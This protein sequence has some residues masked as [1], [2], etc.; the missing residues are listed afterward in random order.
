MAYR[1]TT[2]QDVEFLHDTSAPRYAYESDEEDQLNPLSSGC[3][4]KTARVSISIK[5][6]AHSQGTAK[7][8]VIA[9][10][11]AGN[12]WARGAQLGEQRAAVLV[13][14]IIVALIFLP[15]WSDAVVIISETSATL[16]AW[17]MRPYAEAIVHFY[18]PSRLLLLDTYPFPTCIKPQPLDI[19]HAPVC[20]LRTQGKAAPASFL[21]PY[22]PPNLIQMTCAAFTSIAALPTSQM[23]AILLLLP[24][25]RIPTSR[26]HDISL[27]PN[28]PEDIYNVIWPDSILQ[29]VHICL[30]ELCE[31]RGPS[32]WQSGI[33]PS[34]LPGTKRRGDI[35]DGGMYI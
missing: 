32:S 23:E 15:S 30:G 29:K 3:E 16:P 12:A 8:V 10:G 27:I 26:G 17:V 5:G 19:Y 24:S 1:N 21:S 7:A 22:W 28:T 2:S 11:Q 9:S 6:L 13:D 31:L 33:V 25:P 18:K 20:Y 34:K 14:N 35:G 4:Q